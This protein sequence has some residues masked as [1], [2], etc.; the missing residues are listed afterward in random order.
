MKK[1]I[2]CILL[3]VFIVS[4]G[5]IEARALGPDD[6]ALSY[7]QALKNGDIA[8]IKS[9]ITGEMY[10]KRKV[11]LEQNKT[12][13]DYLENIYQDADFQ[14][15]ETAIQDNT[16]EVTVEVNSPGRQN[17]FVLFLK[18]DDLGNW[19]ISKEISK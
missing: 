13:S 3:A 2:I 15:K 8:T 18:K 9:S 14:I 16:A 6:T 4:F 19:K 7:F 10:Q 1:T 5:T 12:Y 11:L 17:E